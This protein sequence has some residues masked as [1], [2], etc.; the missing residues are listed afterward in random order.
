MKSGEAA[1]QKKLESVN[2]NIGVV[3]LSRFSSSRLPGKALREIN[4][5]AVLGYIIERVS[6]VFPKDRMVIAT[7]TETGDDV[8]AEFAKKQ[9]VGCFR[10]SL[11]N[12]S[13]RFCFA[14]ETRGWDYAVR[15]NGDNIFLDINVLREM[16]QLANDGE[17]DFIS[18][19]KGRTFPKGMSV[20][21]VRTKHYQTLLPRIS[22]DDRYREHVTLYLYEH[23]TPDYFFV[24]NTV[25]KQAEGVQM[26]LDTPEDFDR[27]AMIISNFFS[28]HTDYNMKEIFDIYKRLQDDD[29]C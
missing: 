12:V 29:Q 8:I 18:N 3:I 21:I 13:E 10:G 1:R 6:K 27:S 19:V 4:G 26:A 17:Y 2:K 22:T 5:K 9:G 25:L 14:A 16:T 20:E 28:D 15:I 24:Y 7:S 23:E 11:D